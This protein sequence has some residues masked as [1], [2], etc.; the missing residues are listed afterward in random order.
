MKKKK[1][2]SS[3]GYGENNRIYIFNIQQQLAQMPQYQ[4]L[5][6]SK[7]KKT[8]NKICQ[9]TETNLSKI[10]IFTFTYCYV[11]TISLIKI[12]LNKSKTIKLIK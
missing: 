12:L 7:Y 5:S 9:R 10:A 11:V 3:K 1:K 6:R 4:S 8:W 2:E